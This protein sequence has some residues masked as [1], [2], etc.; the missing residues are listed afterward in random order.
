[1]FRFVNVVFVLTALGIGLCFASDSGAKE[2]KPIALGAGNA[3]NRQGKVSNKP[4]VG[5]ASFGGVDTS[6]EDYQRQPQGPFMLVDAP[7]SLIFQ[8]LE[9]LLQ[10]PI[11]QSAGLPKNVLLSFSSRKKIPTGDA[12]KIFR[13]MLMLNGVAI[14]PVDN[15]YFK[16]VPVAGVSSQV[17]EFLSGRARDLPP[18][19]NFYTKFFE[20]EYIQISD[21]ET[22]LKSSMSQSNAGTFESFPKSNSFWVTDTLLNLQRIEEIIEKLDVSTVQ[23]SLIQIKNSSASEIRERIVALKLD[24]L[25]NAALSADNRT[26]KLIV[27]ASKAS[28]EQIKSLAAELDI[29]SIALLKSEVVYIKHGEA[30]KVVEVLNKIV[31]GQ[32]GTKSSSIKPRAQQADLRPAHEPSKTEAAQRAEASVKNSKQGGVEK[33][34]ENIANKLSS[35]GGASVADAST[36]GENSLASSGVEFSEYVQIVSEERSNAIVIYGTSSDLK[37]IKSIIEKLDIVLLQVKIDVLITEVVLSND[38]VSGLSSFGLGYNTSEVPGFSGST[39]TYGLTNTGISA[40]SVNASESSFS[41]LFDMARENQNVKVLSSP[42]IVT[43]HNKEAEINI[44]QSLP[45][46]TSSMS[47]ITSITT[48]RSSVSYKDIGIKLLVTPLVGNNGSVQLK[49]DQSVDSISGYTTIDG[50]QQPVISKRK[51]TSFVSAKSNEIITLAGLQQV[52]TSEI[53]GGV[54]LLSDIPLLGDLFKPSKNEYKR[55][56]LI[57]FIRPTVVESLDAAGVVESESVKNSPASSEIK[58]FLTRG[59]FYPDNE[60]E[61][62]SADFEKNRLHNKLNPIK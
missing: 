10:R 53:D 26:N 24:T 51:A 61:K 6:S 29:E 16:A 45:I 38:Q 31:S 12:I 32:R 58:T 33:S 55:R 28:T 52:D 36:S 35:V 21:I 22:K 7:L 19:Q 48:T 41:M 1:M 43:T 5:V 8:I 47:D 4:I 56:E 60:L 40:F 14:I 54:W 18:S 17:P 9:E 39:K 25:K 2:D 15:K 57:I 49:I 37:Q 23:T 20:L 50:N 59:K 44:S 46:I 30:A 11:I 34:N 62:K 3:K 13:S 27:T 42:T